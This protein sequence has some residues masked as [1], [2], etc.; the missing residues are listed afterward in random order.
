MLERNISTA[1]PAVKMAD[2]RGAFIRNVTGLSINTIKHR[3][4]GSKCKSVF[5]L[6]IIKK[7][8]P[9]GKQ[10]VFQFIHRMIA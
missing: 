5:R 3:I 1:I 2:V 9:L 8:L 10:Y 4:R 7:F 6:S